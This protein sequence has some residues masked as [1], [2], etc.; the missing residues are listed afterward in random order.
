M[1]RVLEI[2]LLFAVIS[3][4]FGYIALFVAEND[5]NVSQNTTT[6]S[7]EQFQAENDTESNRYVSIDILQEDFMATN[8]K[9]RIVIELYTSVKL[10]KIFINCVKIIHTQVFHFIA[11]LTTL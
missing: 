5:Q 7:K 3:L 9:N 1:E 10:L 4:C 8:R 6:K 2:A 11:L